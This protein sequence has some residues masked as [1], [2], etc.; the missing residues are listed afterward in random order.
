MTHQ[1]S[2]S[3]VY[4]GQTWGWDE[5]P[6]LGRSRM[7]CGV[8][9]RATAVI[10][11]A[12]AAMAAARA[13]VYCASDDGRRQT[14][15]MD[16]RGG[17]RLV[18]QRSG[19]P[20]NQGQTWGWTV[21]EMSGSTAAAVPSSSAAAE[22]GRRWRQGTAVGSGNRLL[23]LRR[24]QTK[25]LQHGHPWRRSPRQSTQRL[26]LQPGTNLGL[27]QRKRLGRPRLPCR[28]P[29]QSLDRHHVQTT[30]HSARSSCLHLRRAKLPAKNPSAT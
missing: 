3:P 23:R 9:R 21:T 6:Y 8:H 18:N 11:V 16:T 7:P 25:H 15:S 14:C 29:I 4:Q 22:T 1:R 12:A 17:V 20:C 27:E 19:S 13:T 30:A 26:T 24:W 10:G 28:I 2:G 5:Q